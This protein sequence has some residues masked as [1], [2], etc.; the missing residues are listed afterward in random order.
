ML[1]TKYLLSALC[2]LVVM[3]MATSA[4]AQG[5]FSV[6][7]SIEPRARMNGQTETAGGITLS[8]ESGEIDGT[9]ESGTVNINYGTTITNSMMTGIAIEICGET[10]AADDATISGSVIALSVPAAGDNNGCTATANDS[11]DVSGVRLAIAGQGL[12]GVAANITSSGRCAARK[13][14]Q[15]GDGHQ[16]HRG[17]SWSTAA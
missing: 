5:V 9:N 14:R 11:I 1:K 15:R 10:A 17:T 16:Q 4:F 8:L 12:T 3:T 7:S 13:R 6:S 2:M